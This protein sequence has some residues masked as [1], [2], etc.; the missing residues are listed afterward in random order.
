MKLRI[1]ILSFLLLLSTAAYAHNITR[2]LAQ[3]PEFST[4]NHYLTTTH[5]ADEINRR[6]TIT[7]CAVDNAA[8]NDL[9]SKHFSLYTI[10]NILSLHIFADYFG[11][12][13]L[14]QITK[15]PP[16]PPSS[17]PPERP[18]EPPDTSTSPT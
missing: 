3:H 6:R 7:V 4:F 9:L 13:K 5:L 17:R 10:K 15:A 12:K 2:I 14:H 11:S 18:P 8:M 16:P 1:L